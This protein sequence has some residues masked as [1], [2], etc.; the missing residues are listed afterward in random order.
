MSSTTLR[1]MLVKQEHRSVN[2]CYV[3]SGPRA[4]YTVFSKPYA[5][6][7]FFPFLD[8]HQPP[9]GAENMRPDGR[10]LTCL[11]CYN[12]LMQQ[13]D[14]YEKNK[15]PH[16][17]R[18]Y[19]LKRL[20]S[21]PFAG[22]DLNLQQDYES[23]FESSSTSVDVECRSNKKQSRS[24]HPTSLDSVKSKLSE[25]TESL[26]SNSFNIPASSNE[27]NTTASN[28]LDLSMPARTPSQP[29]AT[30]SP[31]TS[32]EVCYICGLES[33]FIINV[34]AKPIPNCPYFP[35]LMMHPK[36]AN[37]KPMDNS[38][39]VSA[40]DLCHKSLI[41]QWDSYQR[42][43]VPHHERAYQCKTLTS[44]V[45]QEI[46]MKDKLF[47][48]YTCGMITQL[49]AQRFINAYPEKEG[50]PFFSF[51]LNVNPHPGANK[52]VGGKASVCSLCYKTLFRQL[53]VYELSDTP[54]E[55]RKY[56]IVNESASDSS[57]MLR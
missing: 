33:K 23:L 29:P 28:I 45:K 57:S 46:R 35:S 10:V 19:W 17:K 53:R 56:K 25:R 5:D 15:T 18:I 8:H 48:C 32:G 54:E 11:V 41:Q 37:A 51:L 12:F 30:S 2:Y 38:G 26:Y 20:D 36:P 24:H 39:K 42:Q 16:S 4:E 44:S 27:L 31:V 14:A 1:E 22:M 7:P 6:R 43:N 40:C 13:W 55:K 50:D 49:S 34:F 3:C 9:E 21:G 47:V 52:L